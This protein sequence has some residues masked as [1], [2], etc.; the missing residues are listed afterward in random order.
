VV[1]RRRLVGR[2]CWC[3]VEHIVVVHCVGVS[4]VLSM[5]RAG[6][7]EQATGSTKRHQA[8]PN[9][10]KAARA[11]SLAVSRYR[12]LG[13]AVPS[14]STCSTPS[15]P[16]SPT[17][18]HHGFITAGDPPR[19][20]AAAESTRIHRESTKH[21]P[22]RTQPRQTLMAMT[23]LRLSLSRQVNPITIMLPYRLRLFSDHHI[24]HA[25]NVAPRLYCHA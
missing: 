17:R 22:H 19:S 3:I 10:T 18:L 16:T 9:D 2:R 7:Q 25:D 20:M 12:W 5:A 21:N 23:Q 1:R 8:T 14:Q 15:L 4:V 13:R 24:P 11:R 6:Q